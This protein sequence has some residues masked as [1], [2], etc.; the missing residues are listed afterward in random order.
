LGSVAAVIGSL[1]ATEAMKYL[2]GIGNLLTNALLSYDALEMEFHTVRLNR[3][4][5]CPLCGKNPQITKLKDEE[6]VVCDLKDYK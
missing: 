2:L 3:N 6:Q 4:P 5:D 1:Q